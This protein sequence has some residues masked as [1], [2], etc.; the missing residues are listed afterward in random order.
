MR[1]AVG[2]LLALS[3][4]ALAAD[5]LAAETCLRTKVWDSYADGWGVRTMTSTT[6]APNATRNYLV[7]LYKGNQYQIRTCG[8]DAVSNL[9]VYL[10][11][12][13]GNVIAQD[14][15]TDRE[16][17]IAYTPTATGTFY[18]VVHARELVAGK[19]DA[20]VAMAVT[21]K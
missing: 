21:Y 19:T 7:T 12:L 18:V 17:M 10:Y 9:D 8:D 16:P 20:G 1:F 3:T 6:L 13:G 11:D 15:T 5:E 14:N 2:F 4:A